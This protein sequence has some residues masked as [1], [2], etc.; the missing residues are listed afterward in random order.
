MRIDISAKNLVLDNPLRTFIEEKMSSLTR[1]LGNAAVRVEIARST[2][3]H[4]SGKVYYAEAN[5]KLGRLLLR[6]HAD[7]YDLR[8]AITDVKDDLQV[9]IKKFKGKRATA[10]RKAKK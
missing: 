7:H 1:F 3:H 6:A 10:S 2:R 4:R 5:I 9:Q 8:A